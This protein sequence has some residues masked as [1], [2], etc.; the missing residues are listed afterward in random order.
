LNAGPLQNLEDAS[1]GR[2]PEVCGPS[3]P[4]TCRPGGTSG[5][6]TLSER[7]IDALT[8]LGRQFGNHIAFTSLT[9]GI[10][11][12]NSGHYNGTAVDITYNSGGAKQWNELLSQIWSAGATRAVCEA[13]INGKSVYLNSCDF[14]N[15]HCYTSAGKEVCGEFTNIHIHAVFPATR[16]FEP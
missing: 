5:K 6:V 14:I 16:T 11:G 13:K 1:A 2:L 3:I 15:T 8:S 9:G 10:H 7:L 12:A 4:C